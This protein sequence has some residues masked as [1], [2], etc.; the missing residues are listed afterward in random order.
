MWQLPGDPA[1]HSGRCKCV[2]TAATFSTRLCRLYLGEGTE[3]LNVTHY[4]A[5]AK[6]YH[7]G[8]TGRQKSYLAYYPLVSVTDL[9]ASGGSGGGGGV[10]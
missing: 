3:L 7:T 6:M 1:R 9:F 10:G 5:V 8:G 2:I 4:S